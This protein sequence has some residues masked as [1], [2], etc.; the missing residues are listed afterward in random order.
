MKILACCGITLLMLFSLLLLPGCNSRTTGNKLTSIGGNEFSGP[1]TLQVPYNQAVQIGE[2]TRYLR[3]DT[4]FRD[5]RC[6]EDVN[7]IWKGAWE[8]GMELL[9]R[10]I[11]H[12][13]TLGTYLK[14]NMDTTLAGYSIQVLDLLPRPNTKVKHA[15]SD[16]RAIVVIKEAPPDPASP[17][18]RLP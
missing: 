13:L 7:C 18:G 6:P 2:T 10:D 12:N 1:D 11:T 14:S 4:L 17:A 9:D 16:Y 8:I 3:F 15:K 5:S